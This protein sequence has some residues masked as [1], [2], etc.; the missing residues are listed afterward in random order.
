MSAL[1]SPPR[2]CG[3]R[4]GVG[5]NFRNPHERD[6]VL[7]ASLARLPCGT[8]GRAKAVRPRLVVCTD[9]SGEYDGESN[10]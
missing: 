2:S 8:L 4:N 10:A 5:Q 6:D 3:F 7:V 1:N 9:A